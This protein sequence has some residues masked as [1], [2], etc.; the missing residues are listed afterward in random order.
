M[1]VEVECTLNARPLTYEYNE[2]DDEVMTPH[3]I[4]G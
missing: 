1:L 3:L 4:Y 2:V